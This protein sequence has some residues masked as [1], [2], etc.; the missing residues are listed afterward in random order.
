MNEDVFNM[1][2]RKFLKKVGVTSQRE[3][4]QAVRAAIDSGKLSGKGKLKAR[5]L[6][7]IEE[8]GLKHEIDG[9]IAL[10]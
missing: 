9:K 1:E 5:I 4:E 10:E 2:V 8:V 7:T 3:I 6:L